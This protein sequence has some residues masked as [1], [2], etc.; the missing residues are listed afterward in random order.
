MRKWNNILAR[1]IIVL[2]LLHAL[3][4]SLMLLGL[5][6]YFFFTAFYASAYC[7]SH[8]WNIGKSWPLYRQWQTEKKPEHWYL[9]AK[10]CILDKENIRYRYYVA[11]CFSCNS[12]Y[13]QRK[14]QIFP[15]KIYIVPDVIAD[16]VYTGNFYS[17]CSEHKVYADCERHD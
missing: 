9:K 17:S 16:F 13:N 7:C 3:M 11:A 6:T 2:F 5:N 4:G 12:I 8:S 15:K 1:V 14:W 10:C